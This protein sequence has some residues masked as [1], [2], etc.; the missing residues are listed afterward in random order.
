MSKTTRILL[1]EKSAQFKDSLKS[2]L[3]LQAGIKI[4]GESRS[5]KRAIELTAELKP[6]LVILDMNLPGNT[7]PDTCSSFRGEHQKLK[8]ILMTDKATDDQVFTALASGADGY[9][10]K[11][12]HKKKFEAGTRTVTT[13]DFWLDP[14]I[15]KSVMKT[16]NLKMKRFTAADAKRSVK[17]KEDE[18]LSE[19]ELEVL[20][21]VAMGLSNLQIADNL[22]ISPE[23]VKTH[24]RHIMRKLLVKDRTQAAVKGLRQ[25]LI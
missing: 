9:C 15:A 23:T 11:E 24:I 8:I 21:L 12:L 7:F 19:R 3:S 6:D 17:P 1:V 4:V 5:L 10:L 2:L 13:G 25:G 18:G 14:H 16:V 22:E 20:N